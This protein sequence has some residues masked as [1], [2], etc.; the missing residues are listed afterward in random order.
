MY[1]QVGNWKPTKSRGSKPADPPALGR[2]P[3]AGFPGPARFPTIGPTDIAPPPGGY[4]SIVSTRQ[5]LDAGDMRQIANV[6]TSPQSYGTGAGARSRADFARGIQD[7]TRNTISRAADQFNTDY[8]R[9]AEKSRSEDILAQRQS[10]ADRFR[11]DLFKNIFDVD[12]DTRY[13][14]GIQDLTQYWQ[15][16]RENQKAKRTAMMLRFIGGLL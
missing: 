8:Q 13:T 6:K 4:Q 16:E 2:A 3:K 14:T 1:S 11:M 7:T 12:T 10:S 15:T 5:P 9:Q